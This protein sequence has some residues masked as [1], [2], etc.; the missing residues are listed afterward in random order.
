MKAKEVILLIFIILVGVSISLVYNEEFDIGWGWGEGWIFGYEEFVYEETETLEALSLD[1]L[2][3]RN[4]YGS[5]EI[6]GSDHSSISITFEKRI[7]RKNEADA[8]ALAG[9]LKMIIDQEGQTLTLTNNRQDFKN[10][11]FETHYYITVPA[12]LNVNITNSYGLVKVERVGN[13]D[14]SNRY[15]EVTASEVSGSL[16]IFNKDDEVNIEHAT[17][18]CFI[19]ASYADINL[20]DV[21]GKVDIKN[22]NGKLALEEIAKEVTIRSP[23]CT[24]YGWDITGDMDIENSYEKIELTDVGNV[25]IA[26]NQSPVE[27]DGAEGKIDINNRYSKVRL[28]NIR[29]NISIEGKNLGVSG[30]SIQGEKITIHSS[31]HDIELEDFS[32]ETSITLAHGNIYLT[33]SPLTHPLDIKGSYADIKFFWP[34]SG[35]YPIDIQANQG[36]IMWKLDADVS[37]QKD[38]GLS[39]IKAFVEE[40]GNPSIFLSTDYGTIWIE[41]SIVI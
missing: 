30:N 16:S 37:Y 19:E 6:L 40:S 14:I 12:D 10:K 4:S 29:G 21:K 22:S 25:K 7:W 23:H 41:K 39:E 38:N 32:G 1:Q 2:Q 26:G 33:P 20:R 5:V 28:K 31:Y 3:I 24:I 15:G 8:K 17:S 35:K 27:I 11:K 36:Q 34:E 13:A 18:D 9:Q